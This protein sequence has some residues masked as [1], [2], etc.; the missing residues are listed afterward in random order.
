VEQDKFISLPS[1]FKLETRRV[2]LVIRCAG[3]EGMLLRSLEEALH[4]HGGSF[5][6]T[7]AGE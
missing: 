3:P 2:S 4:K 7:E 5:F 6:E 1:N